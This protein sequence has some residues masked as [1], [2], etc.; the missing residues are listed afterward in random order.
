MALP[1]TGDIEADLKTVLWA[2]A[3]E[4]AVPEPAAR[5]AAVNGS[6]CAARRFSTELTQPVTHPFRSPRPAVRRRGR[7]AGADRSVR[8]TGHP[9]TPS[10]YR[11]DFESGYRPNRARRHPEPHG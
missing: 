10:T 1:D 4:F 5:V 3:V 2:T 9:A 8:P 7:S 11:R 6:S